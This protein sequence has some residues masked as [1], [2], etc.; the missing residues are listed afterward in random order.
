MDKRILFLVII[1][2]KSI[3]YMFKNKTNI[4]IKELGEEDLNTSFFQTLSNLSEV[5]ID[6]HNKEFSKKIFNKIICQ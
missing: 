5:G 1:T 6:I 3:R 4:Q 2:C